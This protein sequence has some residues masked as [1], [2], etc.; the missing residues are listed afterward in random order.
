MIA[1]PKTLSV[2]LNAK[3]EPSKL[4]HSLSEKKRE[5]KAPDDKSAR[6]IKKALGIVSEESGIASEELVDGAV[7]SDV[8]IDS[9]L[10]LTISSRFQDEITIDIDSSTLHSL[11]TIGGLKDFLRRTHAGRTVGDFNEEDEMAD[12]ESTGSY[13]KSNDQA[14]D[15]HKTDVTKFE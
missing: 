3:A 9:L 7:L 1:E 4:R 12:S 8:G 5:T 14:A 13:P 15:T 2:P 11:H 6:V 10:G